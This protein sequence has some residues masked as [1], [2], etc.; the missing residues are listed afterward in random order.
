MGARRTWLRLGVAL[1]LLGVTV[2]QGIPLAVASVPPIDGAVTCLEAA[3]GPVGPGSLMDPPETLPPWPLL[4]AAAELLLPAPDLMDPTPVR[5]LL[6]PA[7][8]SRMDRPPT[9]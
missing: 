6:P 4:S 7:P 1:W 9:P 3:E 2:L 8:L 5:S